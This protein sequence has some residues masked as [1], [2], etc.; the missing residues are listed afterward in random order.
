MIA[1]PFSLYNYLVVEDWQQSSQA[2]AN[3][4]REYLRFSNP[5]LGEEDFS[6]RIFMELL[7]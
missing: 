7:Y 3:D 6:G 5:Q 2:H 4:Y 1:D